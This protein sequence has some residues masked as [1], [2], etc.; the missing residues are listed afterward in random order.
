MYM[1]TPLALRLGSYVRSMCC[2]R[3][4]SMS[5]FVSIRTLRSVQ[6]CDMCHHSLPPRKYSPQPVPMGFSFIEAT[7]E[8]S[9]PLVG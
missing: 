3:C 7:M 9:L 5:R 4:N 2:H 6:R 8:P 1:R